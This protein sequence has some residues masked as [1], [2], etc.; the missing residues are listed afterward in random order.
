[1]SEIRVH[2][3]NRDDAFIVAALVLQ[4]DRAAGEPARAGFLREYADAWLADFD[5]RPTWLASLPDN[6]AIG[7]VQAGLIHK[8]PSLRRSTTSWIH[9]S[10]VYVR[11]TERGQGVAERM[12][13]R[14]IA[15]GSSNGVERYQLN[16]VPEARTLYERLGFSAPT[17]R[18][19]ELLTPS[20]P[21][22]RPFG[23]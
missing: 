12:L 23:R 1:M 20:D 21:A 15:W 6:T 3:A 10:L 4:M 17:D 14:M 11:E 13:H 19:M 18:M 2:L 7:L 5:H 22:I 9:V 16:A 8:M